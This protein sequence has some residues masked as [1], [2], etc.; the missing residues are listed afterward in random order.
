M[1]DEF[2]YLGSLV[3]ADNDTSREIQRRIL[4]RNRAYFGVRRT[5]RSSKIRRRT[6]LTIYKT[7]IRPVILYGHE[8]WTMLAEDQRALGVFER[9]V[10]RTIFGGVRMEDGTWRRRMNHELH[11]LLGGPTLVQT[12]KV[13]RLRWAGHVVRM[14]ENNPVKMILYNDPTGIRRR[15]AQRARWIDQIEDD[16]RTLRS[17]RGWRRTAMNRFEWRRLLYTAETRVVY[18]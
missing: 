5:L 12:A 6:K 18:D 3:T 13:G 15:G 17:Y 2:V 9:K 16:L 10:L 8:S 4:S 11:Q 1:V 7:L 14:S